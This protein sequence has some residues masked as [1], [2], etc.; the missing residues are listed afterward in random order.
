MHK[1]YT[2]GSIP[3]ENLKAMLLFKGMCMLVA[4]NHSINMEHMSM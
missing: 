2:P 4:M 1:A 3:R